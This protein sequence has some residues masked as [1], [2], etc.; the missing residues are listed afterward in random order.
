MGYTRSD[1]DGASSSRLTSVRR[2][3]WGILL[4]N[5]AVAAA[6]LLWGIVSG[7]IAMQADGFHSLFDGTSNVVGLVGMRF[8]SR[9]ADK[10]HPYGHA[11]YETYASAAIGAMLALAAYN[12]G[13]SAIERLMQGGS[14]PRV[15]GVSFA[16][17]LVT[18][19]VNIIVTTW[20]RR[21]GKRLS[22]EILIADANHTGSDVLVSLGVIAGLAAVR[23]GYPI[24]DP[25][26][27]L[28]VAAAIA[29]T[30][31][32]VLRQAAV[33]LSDT[34][35]LPAEAVRQA[36]LEVEGVADC[37]HIRTRG[38]QA[39]IYV[40]LHVQVDAGM[41]LTR[42]HEVAEA[43]ERHVCNRFPG[44]VDVIVHVE[45]Q[46]TY[47]ADKTQQEIDDDLL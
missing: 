4:L 29:H 6:K 26:I 24:A 46:D 1:A 15:T 32:R 3:L 37:H 8:A 42:A 18:L 43:V 38:L 33:T 5:V 45:P 20:E 7:S 27:G 41:P 35:R 17:M 25:V 13:S 9:P 2:V 34:A 36:V 16:I 28:F 30:A 40:D 22:S 14:A 21:V 44:V 23:L 39:E 10:D 19:A 12:V 47:Q 31:I 11:K